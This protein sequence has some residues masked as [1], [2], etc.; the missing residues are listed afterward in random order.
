MKCDLPTHLRYAAWAASDPFDMGNTCRVAFQGPA[1]GMEERAAQESTGSQVDGRCGHVDRQGTQ[2]FC[3][4]PSPS[5][6]FEPHTLPRP[7]APS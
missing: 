5:Y 6:D 3:A 2:D 7:T 4:C 1:E